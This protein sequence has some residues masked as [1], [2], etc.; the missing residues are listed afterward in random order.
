MIEIVYSDA[1]GG[2][3][4]EFKPLD[5][6]RFICFAD[7]MPDIGYLDKELDSDYRRCLY[8]EMFNYAFPV[9]YSD[10]DD[11]DC[12]MG[13]LFDASVESIKAMKERASTG[14]AIRIWADLDVHG[15]CSTAFICNILSK[16]DGL[17]EVLVMYPP[18]FNFLDDTVYPCNCWGQFCLGNPF[19]YLS[20]Q[21]KMTS[22]E[23]QFY[24]DEWERLK[25]E[26]SNLRTLICGRLESVSEDFYDNMLLKYIPFE[27]ITEQK[28]IGDYLADKRC[29]INMLIPAWRIQ[30]LIDCGIIEVVEKVES[31]RYFLS[32]KIKRV[33]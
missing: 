4:K 16:I 33:L 5:E 27:P 28:A 18:Q 6:D 30:R 15:Q 17:G 9:I 26:N 32:R 8:N 24:S 7:L 3:L 2:T 10:S 14:E 13:K 11:T 31:D 23:M 20:L 12:D 25:S 1:V 22:A 19:D 21:R 29:G